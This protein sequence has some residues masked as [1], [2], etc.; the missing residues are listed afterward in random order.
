MFT[1]FVYKKFPGIFTQS[2]RDENIPCRRV[3]LV[4]PYQGREI[5]NFDNF[6]GKVRNTKHSTL[7]RNNLT[8]NF[9][10]KT[11]FSHRNFTEDSNYL[12]ELPEKLFKHRKQFC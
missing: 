8:R 10:P 1:S 3:I 4:L 5:L 12:F 11:A 7:N 2:A 6:A 9:A